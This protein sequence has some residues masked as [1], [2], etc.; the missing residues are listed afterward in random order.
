MENAPNDQLKY[1]KLAREIYAR[2]PDNRN[3]AFSEVEAIALGAFA[4]AWNEKNSFATDGG[5]H[6]KFGEALRELGGYV[7][8][9][10]QVRPEVER[11]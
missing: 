8:G 3:Y 11:G 7:P 1:T 6:E 10:Y 2:L 4:K 5:G 9:L